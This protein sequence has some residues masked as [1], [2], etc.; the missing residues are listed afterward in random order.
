MGYATQV[1]AVADPKA[2]KAMKARRQQAAARK[3]TTVH[4][5]LTPQQREELSD[6]IDI[7]NIA[8]NFKT[9]SRLWTNISNPYTKEL[10]VSHFI[11]KYGEQDVSIEKS[12]HHYVNM[13]DNMASQNPGLLANPF[14]SILQVVAIIEYDF[15][16][17]RDK[18]AMA[19]KVLGR[20]G[21]IKNKER[22]GIK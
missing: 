14:S 21:Y 16:N 20:E 22:L 15:G 4:Q 2:L 7:E 8:S 6:K 9:S 10:L 1:W 18:D 3:T 13:I 12:P 5:P 11:D 19:L 17:G